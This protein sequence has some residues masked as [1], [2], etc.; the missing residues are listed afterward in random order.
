MADAGPP[1]SARLAR[2]TPGSPEPSGPPRL[3]TVA[4]THRRPVDRRR[5]VHERVPPPAGPARPRLHDAA[6]PRRHGLDAHR[7]RGPRPRLRPRSPPT[8]PSGPAAASGSSSPAASRP[9]L[10]GC[11]L[12]GRRPCS[13]TRRQARQHRAGHDAVHARAARSPCRSCTRAATPT[14]RSR[15]SAVGGQVADLAASRPRALTGPRRPRHRRAPTPAARGSP[16][17]PATT[18]SRSWAPRATCSTSSSRRAPTS[19]PTSWGGSPENRRRF[20]VEIVRAVREAVGP[21]FIVVYR[22]SMLDLVPDGPDLGRDRRAGP[23]GRGGRG[24]DHQHSAS[25]GTRRA[26]RRSSRPCRAAP[27]PRHRQAAPGARHRP[28]R[29]V[30][31]HQHARRRR[32]GPRRRAVP[33][34][35]RWP[36]RSSPTPTGCSRPRRPRPTRSTRASPATRPA[37]TTPSSK[38]TATCLVNPRAGHETELVLAPTRRAKRVAVVGAGPAGSAPRPPRWPSAG[39]RSSSSRPRDDI[40]GQFDIADAHPRQGG[41]RRDHPLLHA[42]ARPRRA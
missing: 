20:A 30:E 14:T 41:V 9:N 23:R 3:H 39:T 1:A 25:A 36:G 7:A 8:S 40:G 27:S 4:A 24:D 33:T 22:L 2:A 26:C 28:G 31:P 15:C 13:S 19:A 38:K 34:S 32:A 6:Q 18:A 16:A 11:A 5:R 29:H 12:P 21:D 35:S 10:A 42:A 37:S 17:R